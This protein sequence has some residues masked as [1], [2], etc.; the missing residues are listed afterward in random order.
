MHLVLTL[1]ALGAAPDEIRAAYKRNSSYQ[2]PVLPSNES[3]IQDMH[4]PAKFIQCLGTE[5]NY[6]NFLAFFQRE[7]DAKGVADV[8]REYL[9]ATDERTETMLSRLYGGTHQLLSTI[10]L[11]SR[12]HSKLIVFQD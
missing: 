8:L 2:R 7:I 5:E 9:F 3:V 4:D 12:E 10:Y 1:Y 6:P 11:T